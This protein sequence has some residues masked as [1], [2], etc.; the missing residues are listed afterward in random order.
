MR[1]AQRQRL[2]QGGGAGQGQGPPGGGRNVRVI[3]DGGKTGVHMILPSSENL[4]KTKTPGGGANRGFSR[5]SAGGPNGRAWPGT[6]R[7]ASG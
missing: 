3:A 2:A 7:R 5:S 6:V 1:R 4:L